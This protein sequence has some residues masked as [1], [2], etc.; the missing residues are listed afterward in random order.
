[1]YQMAEARG[2]LASL[3]LSSLRLIRSGGSALPRTLLHRV[4]RTLGCEV[5]NTYG[6]TESCTA[7]RKC[8]WSA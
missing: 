5:L 3:D 8:A 2:E 4:R 1:M 6:T 7:S